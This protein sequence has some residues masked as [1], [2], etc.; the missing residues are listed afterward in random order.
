[1]FESL[2][3]LMLPIGLAILIAYAC[4]FLLGPALIPMLRR[5]KFGQTVRDDGPSGHLKKNG[6]P[7]MGGLAIWA[8]TAVGALAAFWAD[9]TMAIVA[10]IS[11]LGF[12]AIGFADDY[13]K[14]KLKRSLGLTAWQK[15]IGQ[16]VLAFLLAWW[17]SRSPQGTVWYWPW[18]GSLDLGWAFIPVMMVLLVGFTNSVNLIDGLDGLASSVTAVVMAAM[19]L[20]IAAL[21]RAVDN[22]QLA[23]GLVGLAAFCGGAAGACMAFLRV[24][25]YPAQVFMGDTGSMFLG[26]AVVAVFAQ[27]GLMLLLPIIGGMYAATALSVVLQVGYYKLTHKRIFKM[28]PLHHHFELSGMPETRV[29]AMY[30]AITALLCVIALL[31]VTL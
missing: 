10:L 31:L 23:R 9:G 13:V 12:G 14:V 4:C 25:A 11:A 8:A 5:L 18:G 27:S 19:A 3:G 6:T 29:V 15:L 21:S 7:T 1:M 24:N 28:A 17:I 20:I 2:E 22:E 26:G 16:F 30:T